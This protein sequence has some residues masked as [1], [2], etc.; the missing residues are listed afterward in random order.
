MQIHLTIDPVNDTAAQ[1]SACAVFLNKLAEPNQ[2]T[3]GSTEAPAKVAAVDE[4][5][6]EAPKAKAKA[7][8]A[9]TAA[10]AKPK[11][12][13]PDE[14]DD[15]EDYDTLRQ[16]IR[17]RFAAYAEEAGAVEGKA[18]LDEHRVEKFSQLENSQL[19][20]FSKAL[21]RREAEL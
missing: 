8:P 10:K 13:E 12:A 1:L 5:E 2:L 14:E 4:P 16:E 20:A 15:G 9:A 19:K 6:P 17:S 18:L 21:T 3:S 11:A 7:K